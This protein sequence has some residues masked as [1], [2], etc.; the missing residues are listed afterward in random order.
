MIVADALPAVTFVMLGA[1]GT[2]EGVTALEAE[3][4]AEVPMP[5]VAV[6]VKVYATPFV[7]PVTVP[8]VAEAPVTFTNAPPGL[9]VTV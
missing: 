3:D 2:V 1:S 8:C 6:T 7:R 4:G 5:F 9:A